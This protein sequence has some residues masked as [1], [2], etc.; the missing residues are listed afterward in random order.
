MMSVR[1]SVAKTLCCMTWLQLPLQLYWLCALCCVYNSFPATDSPLLMDV[2]ATNAK[3]ATAGI[4]Y[5]IQYCWTAQLNAA[6]S[7]L[8]EAGHHRGCR[9]IKQFIS[10]VRV[11]AV[12]APHEVL[13]IS[14]ACALT[15]QSLRQ[16]QWWKAGQDQ[17]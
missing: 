2:V 10:M 15:T 9:S 12:E 16:R 1:K 4:Q 7:A 5:Q 13:L 8:I 11:R 17:V 6:I 14:L 3:L